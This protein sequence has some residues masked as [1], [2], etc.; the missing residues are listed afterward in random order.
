MDT[1]TI[2]AIE[3]RMMYGSDVRVIEQVDIDDLVKQIL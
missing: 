2:F 3:Q 1:Q